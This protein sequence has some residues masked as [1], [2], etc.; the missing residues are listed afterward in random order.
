TSITPGKGGLVLTGQ[1]GDVMKES[2]R[3]ALT[4]AKSNAER[5]GI[6]TKDLEEREIHIHVPSGGTP[7]EGPSAGLALATSLVSALTGTP[8][9]K[10]VAMTGEITLRGRVLPIGGPKEKILGAKRAG[11]KHIVFP[12]KNNADMKDVATHLTK[13]LQVHEVDDIDQALDAALV[14]GIAA[15][16]KRVD[17]AGSSG[18]GGAGKRKASPR[19]PKVE[20]GVRA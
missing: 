2:A 11:I 13:S 16:E 12:S 7:K 5:F 15:L 8:V 18:K 9:R 4:Y 1:L 20:P 17:D 6:S 14:G 3:A 10:D 19:R